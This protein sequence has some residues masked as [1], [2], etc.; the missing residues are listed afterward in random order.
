MRSSRIVPHLNAD[1]VLS[2][3]MVSNRV[4]GEVMVI[5]EM[6]DQTPTLMEDRVVVAVMEATTILRLLPTK[7]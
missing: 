6:T 7:V 2:L 4:E 3:P 5:V 1:T